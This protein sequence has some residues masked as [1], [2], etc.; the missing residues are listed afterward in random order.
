MRNAF[1]TM[2]LLLAVI[3]QA[4]PLHAEQ[5]P[6]SPSPPADARPVELGEGV[7]LPRTAFDEI[8]SREDGLAA[9]ER[10]QERAQDSRRFEG[11]PHLFVIFI[12]LL[13][14]FWSVMIY[15]QI[16]HARLHRT[17]R[18]MVE[19]GVPLPAEIL[20]A[21]EQFD[22]DK[23]EAAGGVTAVAAPTPPWASNLLWG[24]V[25]WMTIGITGLVYLHLRDS[26]AWPWAIGALVYGALHVV[27]AL[28]KRSKQA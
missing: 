9:I 11:V 10:M 23:E 27:T 5:G 13:L 25:L 22:T 18:L 21:A 3:G 6:E 26:D 28:G 2:L 20:R 1:R 24:G 7:V 16:K 15:Y 17:I 12:A 4:T 8:I 19:K 14:F